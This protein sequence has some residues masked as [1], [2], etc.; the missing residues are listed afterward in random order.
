MA[1]V[2]RQGR[3]KPAKI[4]QR[5]VWGP[6]WGPQVEQTA[7]LASP[8]YID[9]AQEEEKDIKEE[10]KGS[11]S[12]SLPRVLACSPTLLSTSLDRHAHTPQEWI[13]LLFSKKN[14]AVTWSCNTGLS[15]SYYTVCSRPEELWHAEGL[16]VR[17]SKF[18][19]WWDRTEENTLTWH[20]EDFSAVNL[21]F[22]M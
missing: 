13:L 16:N 4:E 14:R 3:E 12:L 9:Q 7:L 20:L 2:K 17:H 21:T 10:P 8:I 18:L 15:K 6:E 1:V 22:N 11:L 19:L 5:T